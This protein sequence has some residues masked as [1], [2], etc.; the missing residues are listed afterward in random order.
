MNFKGEDVLSKKVA[1]ITGASSGIGR[2]T[3]EMFLKKDYKVYGAARTES[4]LKY[5]SEYENGDYIL[6][7]ITQAA[8]RKKCVDQIL[9]QEDKIDILINNAGY[10]SFG[11]VEEVPIE[12]VKKQFEVNLFGLSELTK[13]VIPKMRENEYGK[14]INISSIAG[15]V[16]TPLGGWYHASKFA[17]EGLS[18]CLRHELKQFN[19]D[20]ILIEPGAVKS[21]WAEITAKNLLKISGNGPYQN[22]A[23]KSAEKYKEMYKDGGI[24]VDAKKVAAAIIKAAEKRKPKA[25]YAVPGH[26]KAILFFRWLLSDKIYD[27]FTS[28]FF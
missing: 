4:D 10:G 7:D 1:L 15:K 14:I 24:A 27:Y 18:D 28:K 13:L 26:A 3:A 19:I 9:A 25:R 8:M 2:S 5:L 21:N 12:E 20:V 11:A 6:M 17:L 23:E 16:W 22:Q